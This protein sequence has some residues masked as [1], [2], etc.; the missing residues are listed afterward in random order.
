MEK[1]FAAIELANSTWCYIELFFN[2]FSRLPRNLKLLQRE[3]KP[4]QL[5][6]TK[7]E[8]LPKTEIN[9]TTRVEATAKSFNSAIMLALNK[10]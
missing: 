10:T 1:H 4:N 8:R 9:L 5:K 3:D 2:G 7:I 6:K